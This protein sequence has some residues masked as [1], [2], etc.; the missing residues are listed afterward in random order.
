MLGDCGRKFLQY[1]YRDVKLHVVL[2]CVVFPHYGDNSII[3]LLRCTA[4]PLEHKSA[5][6]YTLGDIPYTFTKNNQGP[7]RTLQIFM[8]HA[9]ITF[10]IGIV[11]LDFIVMVQIILCFCV[12][13]NE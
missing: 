12:V 9:K 8:C 3:G 1:H 6:T 5:L 11:L 7:N 4:Y 2:R 10:Y 13:Q